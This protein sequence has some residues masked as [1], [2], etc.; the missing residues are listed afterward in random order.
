M[1]YNNANYSRFQ[2]GSFDGID[3]SENN[4]YKNGF[5][6][7]CKLT[8][9]IEGEIIDPFA[10]NCCWGTITND[11]DPTTK[12]HYN[13]DALEFLKKMETN[14]AKII[15]FDPPFSASQE[16]KYKGGCQNLYANPTKISKM[17][18]EMFR[19]LKSGGV[20][21]KLGYNSTRP[22]PNLELIDCQLVNFGGSKNDVI[23]TIWQLKIM[24]LNEICNITGEKNE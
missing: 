16:K 11:L 7:A 13:M 5:K 23:Q 22:N 12:A 1:N 8:K 15:L 17:Y 4:Y 14:S 20:I 21:L 24:K 6:K 10:R 2:G 18:K 3:T 19:I 9:N